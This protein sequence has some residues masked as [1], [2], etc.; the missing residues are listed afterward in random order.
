VGQN[1]IDIRRLKQ[2]YLGMSDLTDALSG[3][4]PLTLAVILFLVPNIAVFFAVSLRP[5]II[6]A[7]WL[8]A[9]TPWGIV[10]AAF[11]HREAAHLL[12]NLLGFLVA[13]VLFALSN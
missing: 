6:E 13:V 3:F 9:R 11:L 10:T 4:R 7:L 1:G 2:Y 5:E 8:S 12:Q